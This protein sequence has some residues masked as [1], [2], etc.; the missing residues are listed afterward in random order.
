MQRL[1]V[2]NRVKGFAVRL[3]HAALPCRAMVAAM[4]GKPRTWVACPSCSSDPARPRPVQAETYSHI[5]LDCPSYRP[6]V[7]WLARLWEALS[8]SAPPLDA[9]T[10]ITAAPGSWQPAQARA[11]VWHS[12]RLLTLFAIWEAR[13]SDDAALQTPAAVVASVIRSVETEIRLQYAR[14]CQREEHARHL[15]LHVLAM[16]RLQSAKDDFAAWSS[17]GLCQVLAG[18]HLVVTLSASWPVPA[19]V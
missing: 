18:G 2:S 19:P 7:Q 1:P 9:G 8:T 11:P 14:C 4:R 12:L 15:P 6:A 3:L 17:V 5:F 16:R 13:V 10:I